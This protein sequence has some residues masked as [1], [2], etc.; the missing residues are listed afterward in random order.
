MLCIEYINLNA[1]K[2]LENFE[3]IKGSKELK[4]A[5]SICDCC[6]ELSNTIKDLLK[7]GI[8]GK[9]EQWEKLFQLIANQIATKESITVHEAQQSN[10]F[11]SMYYSLCITPSDYKNQILSRANTEEAK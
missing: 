4:E 1:K 7:L 6:Y 3:A 11:E 8:K 5:E 10:L 2:I 9:K